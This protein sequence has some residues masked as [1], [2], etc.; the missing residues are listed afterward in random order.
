[1]RERA[2]SKLSSFLTRYVG[3]WKCST[4]GCFSRLET[5]FRIWVLS[6]VKS[7]LTRLRFMPTRLACSLQFHPLRV[8][9]ITHT[10]IFCAKCNRRHR[11]WTF[12]R[13]RPSWYK[14][15]IS[16]STR[17]WSRLRNKCL[18]GSNTRSSRH[19]SCARISYE[20]QVLYV[21]RVSR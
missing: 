7:N 8:A 17:V 21:W 11:E 2:R 15:V 14:I 3:E 19:F 10:S 9:K 4:L 12:Q 5:F 16:Y 13:W 1:M 20:D 6:I 18:L